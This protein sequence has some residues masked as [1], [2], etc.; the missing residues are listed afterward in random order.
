MNDK[1][2][3]QKDS[4]AVVVAY[5]KNPTGMTTDQL[6]KHTQ[7]LLKMPVLVT[8]NRG[9]HSYKVGEMYE[10]AYWSGGSIRL[11]DSKGVMGNYISYTDFMPAFNMGDVLKN[12]LEKTIKEL[13]S[14]IVRKKSIEDFVKTM[15]NTTI[16]KALAKDASKINLIN[17]IR[18]P[19]FKEEDIKAVL[20]TIVELMIT[21]K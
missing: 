6:N 1:I 9:N 3:S 5:L 13:D 21:I 16:E 7:N 19:E 20:P 17:L 14:M 8:H 12:F 10:V 11:Q 15:S 2:Q 4:Y 18:I